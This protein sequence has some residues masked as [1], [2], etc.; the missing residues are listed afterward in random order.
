MKTRVCL[1]YFVHG[2]SNENCIYE[3]SK[4]LQNDLRL[5]KEKIKTTCNDSLV[6][7]PPLKRKTLLIL[8]KHY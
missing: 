7:W 5:F 4:E 1:K 8:V 6:P 2:C 3:L